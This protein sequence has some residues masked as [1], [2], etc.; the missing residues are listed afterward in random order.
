[1]KNRSIEIIIEEYDESHVIAFVEKNGKSMLLIFG[2]YDFAENMEFW[3]NDVTYGS[4]NGREGL[5][6]KSIDRVMV[7]MEIEIFINQYDLTKYNL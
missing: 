5:I 1:M 6:F 7:K 2:L 4:K 3:G